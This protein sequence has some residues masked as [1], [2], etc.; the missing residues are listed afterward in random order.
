MIN[1]NGVIAFLVIAILFG[2]FTF[3]TPELG[4]FLDPTTNTYGM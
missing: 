1:R 3:I 2:V 4:I